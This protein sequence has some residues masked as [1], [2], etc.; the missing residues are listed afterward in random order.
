MALSVFRFV[1]FNLTFIML[2]LPPGKMMTDCFHVPIRDT[3]LVVAT[4]RKTVSNLVVGT[5]NLSIKIKNTALK[6]LRSI[7]SSMELKHQQ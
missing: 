1:P 6:I 3:L 4:L 7:R 2:N 5:N